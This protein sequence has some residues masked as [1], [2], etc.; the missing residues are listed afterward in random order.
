VFNQPV[1]RPLSLL[2]ILVL[3][4]SNALLWQRLNRMP[5]TFATINLSGTAVAPQATGLIVISSDGQHGTLVVQQLPALPAAQAYQLWLR[6][7]GQRIS[8]GVFS[9]TD[10]GYRSL[11]VGAPDPLGSYQEFGVT[12]EPAGGSHDPTGA[13]VLGNRN[14]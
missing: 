8:G 2:L 3:V 4:A 14:N 13:K 5:A 9:V 11:W 1:W 10:D 12:I 7:D 6:K